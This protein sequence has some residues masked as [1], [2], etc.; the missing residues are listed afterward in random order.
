[1]YATIAKQQQ[2]EQ[3]VGVCRD[4]IFGEILART[5]NGTA[6]RMMRSC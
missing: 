4:E 5:K 2:Q 3:E 1:M 6:T